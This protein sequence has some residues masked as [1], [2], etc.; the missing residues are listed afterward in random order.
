MGNRIQLI[1]SLSGRELHI[2]AK[3]EWANLLFLPVWLTFWTIGGVMAMKWV[4]HP[5]PSTPRAFISLWL[6]GWALGEA[7][8]A[9]Q[10]AW[11]ALGKEI[12][13][14][15]QGMLTIRRDVLGYGRTRSF[16]VGSVAKLRASGIFP[17]N[18]YWENYLTTMKLAGG[19]IGFESLGKTHRFGIQ[20]TEPEAEHVVT[21]LRP[22]LA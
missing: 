13:K 4:I 21:E 7:F 20:L 8:A 3:K 12:V 2:R 6:V 11:T 22:F 18:S 9:Y 1:P 16:P 14:I 15:D 19:T 5:G 10:W 17:A